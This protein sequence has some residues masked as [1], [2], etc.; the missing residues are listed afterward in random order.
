MKASITKALF[1]I[2]AVMLLVTLACG[3]SDNT[4]TATEDNTIASEVVTEAPVEVI[5]NRRTRRGGDRP[6]VSG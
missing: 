2:I 3:S 6:L 1:L 4:D 5:C